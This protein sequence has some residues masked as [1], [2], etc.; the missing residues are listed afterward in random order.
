MPRVRNRLPREVCVLVFAAFMIAIGYGVVAP[1]LPVFAR[2]VD[3]SVAISISVCVRTGWRH[4]SSAILLSHQHSA[5]IHL[6]QQGAIVDADAPLRYDLKPSSHARDA[7]HP[8]AAPGVQAFEGGRVGRG[9]GA[10]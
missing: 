10:T 4:G 8:R 3:V 1:A 9:G 6:A 5:H 2:S 7:Q